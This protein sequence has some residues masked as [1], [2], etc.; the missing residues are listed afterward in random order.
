MQNELRPQG[1]VLVGPDAA[2]AQRGKSLYAMSPEGRIVAHQ[3]P[4]RTFVDDD[5]G[6]QTRNVHH[7]SPFAGAT[8]TDVSVPYLLLKKSR[9]VARF[10]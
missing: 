6:R 8:R 5:R 1:G 4:A 10:T 3:G 9:A 7:S 2:P